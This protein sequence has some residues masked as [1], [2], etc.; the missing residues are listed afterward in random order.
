MPTL[1]ELL[2]PIPGDNPSGPY[3]RYDPIYDKLK[4]ARRDDPLQD[5]PVRADWRQVIELTGSTI[6]KKSKDLQ[7]AAW[8]TEGLLQRDG[9]SGLRQGLELIQQLLERYWDT[10]HPEI[11]EDGDAEMRAAPLAWVGSYLELPIRLAPLN[12]NGDS[13]AAYRESRAVPTEQEAESDDEARERR[14]A[15]LAEGRLDPEAPELAVGA[16]V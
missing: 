7:L 2:A 4:E 10:V 3:L 8:H 11:D 12:R 14:E 1:E 13:Y 5:P 6:A 9:L 15:A 16:R